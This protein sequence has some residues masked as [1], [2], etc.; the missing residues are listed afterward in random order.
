MNIFIASDHAGFFMKQYLVANLDEQLIDLG[1]NNDER[2]DYP[3]FAHKLASNVFKSKDSFGILMCGSGIGMSI[4]A[5][6]HKRI[7]AALCFNEYMAEMSRKHNNANIIIFGAN[8]ITNE[9][10]INCVRIFLKTKFDGERHEKRLK[11]IDN[12]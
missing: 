7:R 6:R 1:P 8:V 10:A 5:N 4:A 2:C 9:T 3:I 12:Y 11:L